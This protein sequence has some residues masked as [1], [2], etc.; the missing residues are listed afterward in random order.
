MPETPDSKELQQLTKD[1][2]GLNSRLSDIEHK[3]ARMREGFVKNDLGVED[4]DGHRRDH[5]TRIEESKVINGYK[6]GIT[7]NALWAGVVGVAAMFGQ[8]M[9][10]WLRTHIK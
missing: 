8:A 7:Q 9:L 1:V 6:R 3:C 4:Y 10:E 5:A 2:Q